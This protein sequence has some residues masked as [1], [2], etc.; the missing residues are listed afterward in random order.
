MLSI[1]ASDDDFGRIVSALLEPSDTKGRGRKQERSFPSFHLDGSRQLMSLCFHALSYL[2]IRNRIFETISWLQLSCALRI[3]E[4]QYRQDELADIV[5][6]PQ[7][8]LRWAVE[9][10]L[11]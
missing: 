11:G 7:A 5:D 4:P 10:N 3:D 2:D 6:I 9:F 1:I 8:L